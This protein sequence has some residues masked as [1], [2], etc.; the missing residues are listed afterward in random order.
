MIRLMKEKDTLKIVDDQHG[1]PT[2]AIDLAEATLKMIAQMNEGIPIQGIYHF[3]NKGETTWYQFA[4]TIKELANLSCTL[5]PVTSD[6]F[7]TPAKRP[8]YSVLDTLKI[9]QLLNSP[10]QSWEA[11]LSKCIVQLV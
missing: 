8:G 1:R 2:S 5:E 7:P 3:A 10:I 11:A 4:V 6:A 9:E